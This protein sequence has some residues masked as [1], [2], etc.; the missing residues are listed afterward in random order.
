MSP[1]LVRK[2]EPYADPLQLG[3]FAVASLHAELVC[4]PKPGLVTPF[5]SGSH[6]DMD[7]ATFMRSLFALRVYFAEIS[8][9][10]AR[11]AEFLELKRLG[12]TAES[13]MLHATRGVNTHRG[14]I[15]SL[16]L[17]VAAAAALRAEG[18][19]F[20][21]AESVCNEVGQ[22]WGADLLS[23]PLD[24]TSHGQMAARRYSAGGARAEAASGFP[25]LREIALPALRTCLVSGLDPNATLAHCLMSL[26]CHMED[27]NLLHRGG[28]EGLVF[29]QKS[30]RAFLADGGARVTGWQARLSTLAA[31]FVARNL[32]PGASADLLACAWF[33]VKLEHG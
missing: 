33:L 24:A 25:S 1:R 30:A 16:G 11:G 19:L 31:E 5:D 23:A 8:Q 27:T 21:R 9:A 15:F 3:R 22:R 2:L 12:V 28:R 17:L 7:A 26:I 6:R 14:A 32:S 4:A 10:G 20:P 13:V 18:A 29:A